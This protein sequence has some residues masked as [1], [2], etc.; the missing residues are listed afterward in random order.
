V[1]NYR[2]PATERNIAIHSWG[3]LKDI[4]IGMS[5]LFSFDGLYLFMPNDCNG[6]LL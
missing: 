2:K 6:T 1:D 3:E 4:S 5:F